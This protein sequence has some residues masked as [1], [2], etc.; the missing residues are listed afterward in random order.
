MFVLLACAILACG[1]RSERSAT[2]AGG[3]GG[4][5]AIGAGGDGGTGAVGDGGDGGGGDA[6]IWS[7][8]FGDEHCQHQVRLAVDGSDD[9]LMGGAFMGSIDLGGGPLDSDVEAEGAHDIYIAKL[10]PSG[11][12]VWS[13]RLGGEGDKGLSTIVADDTG[14][15]FL[16]GWFLGNLEFPTGTLIGAGGR[17]IFLA[18]LDES[19]N[20]LWAKGF[21]DADSLVGSVLAVSPGGGAVLAGAFRGSLDFGG[22][23]LQSTPGSGYSEDDGFVAK[24]DANG[25]HVW[26]F[27]FGEEQHQAV[28]DVALDPSGEVLVAGYFEGN[29]DLGGGVLTSAGESDGFV[30]KL[31]ANGQHVWSKSFGGLDYTAPYFIRSDSLGNVF[32][33]GEF[34][35]TFDIG[36]GPLS[37]VG[38]SDIF[39]A[40]LDASGNHIWSKR[41]GDADT[42]CI[43]WA[44]AVD[45]EDNLLVTGPFEGDLEFGGATLSSAGQ[46]DAYV[47]KLDAAGEHHWSLRIGDADAQDGHAVV[48]DSAGFPLVGGTFRGT[49]DLGGPPLVCVGCWDVYVAKLWP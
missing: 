29:V 28:Y 18:K 30:G 13:R 3:S 2:W 37:N 24:L 49:I 32:V 31:D 23:V 9:V 6:A 27:R 17:D 22:G 44:F 25:Q 4:T 35:G 42:L 43:P 33:V 48:A 7:R 12:H 47:V 21:G 41:F 34:H 11:D 10:S 46:W 14:N 40:K 8:R 38:K 15:I 5:G 36:G 26:S 39:V 1:A 20:V 19:G 16:T 45:A